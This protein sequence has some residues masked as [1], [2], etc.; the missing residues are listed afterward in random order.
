MACKRYTA[1]P[2]SHRSVFSALTELSD[3]VLIL[4]IDIQLSAADAGRAAAA[5]AMPRVGTSTCS[6]LQRQIERNGTHTDNARTSN[7]S[8]VAALCWTHPVAQTCRHFFEHSAS[9]R[10]PPS[11]MS[12]RAHRSAQ[13][14]MHLSE[15]CRESLCEPNALAHE[16]PSVFSLP[17]WQRHVPLLHQPAPPLSLIHI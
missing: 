7:G 9:Q 14:L 17:G 4:H 15:H 5:T 16:P 10:A 11:P 2:Y 13:P 12:W 6:G 1:V 3:G 8:R